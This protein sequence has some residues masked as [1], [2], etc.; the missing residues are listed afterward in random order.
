MWRVP[1]PRPPVDPTND[2]LG[3]KAAPGQIRRCVDCGAIFGSLASMRRIVSIGGP[4]S[5]AEDGLI[6]FDCMEEDRRIHGWFD[7][8]TFLVAQYG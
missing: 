7:P 5:K 4:M 1:V 3:A 6:Y 2:L 8:E